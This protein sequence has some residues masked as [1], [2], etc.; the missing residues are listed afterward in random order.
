MVDL[1]ATNFKLTERA[2]Q[3]TMYATG[4]DEAAVRN[5]LRHCQY[6]VKVAIVSLLKKQT[7]E[8]AQQ[9]LDQVDG[10]VRAAL[11]SAP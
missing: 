11:A 4:A 10:S 7:V 2:V 6:Q 8:Q 9:L 3:L 5:V 1:Q